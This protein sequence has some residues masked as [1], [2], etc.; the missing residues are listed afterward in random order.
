VSHIA[1]IEL[2]FLLLRVAKLPQAKLVDESRLNVVVIYMLTLVQFK[3]FAGVG[4][5]SG[6]YL[7]CTYDEYNLDVGDFVDSLPCFA[8]CSRC[9]IKCYAC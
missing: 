2:V 6:G 4:I 8:Q 5:I 7:T 3:Y 9:N 1:E